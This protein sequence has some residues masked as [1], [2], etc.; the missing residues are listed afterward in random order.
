MAKFDYQS[1]RHCAKTPDL[2]TLRLGEFD[3]Q[4]DR[5]CA[6]TQNPCNAALFRV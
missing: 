5:H 1:D 2:S 3:Y 4:S 6:K